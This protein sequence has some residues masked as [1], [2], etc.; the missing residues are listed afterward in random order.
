MRIF[1]NPGNQEITYILFS[2]LAV[3]IEVLCSELL[4]LNAICPKESDV[5]EDYNNI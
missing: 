4:S 5:A 3:P 2:F 1:G